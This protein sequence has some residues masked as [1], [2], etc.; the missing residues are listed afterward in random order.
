MTFNQA[1]LGMAVGRSGGEAHS[2][3]VEELAYF[4]PHKFGIKVTLDAVGEASGVDKE[5][6]ECVGES[7]AIHIFEAIHPCFSSCTVDE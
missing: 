3:R 7:G 2:V 5:F 1:I 6:P 4:A